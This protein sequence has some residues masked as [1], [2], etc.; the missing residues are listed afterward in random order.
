MGFRSQRDILDAINLKYPDAKG[1][2]IKAFS[3]I[4]PVSGHV[5][6][7]A[8][9]SQDVAAE[10]RS[11]ATNLKTE[12]LLFRDSL[13][14]VDFIGPSIDAGFRLS[15]FARPLQLVVSPALAYYFLKG[16]KRT[17][18]FRIVGFESLKGVAKGELYPAV[19]YHENWDGA[20]DDFGYAERFTDALVQRVCAGEHESIEVLDDVK[21]TF[22]DDLYFL[23]IDKLERLVT[24][25][26]A[27]LPK[28]P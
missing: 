26:P 18:D 4:A 27:F 2:S 21:M 19:W 11:L 10:L 12:D 9:P 17:N 14:N 24:L 7:A 15:R 23:E 8:P 3:W 16:L 25:S 20:R 5:E 6:L 1:L 28:P 22:G 13:N